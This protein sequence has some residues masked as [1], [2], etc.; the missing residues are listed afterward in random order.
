MSSAP[1][2]TIPRNLLFRFRFS[3]HRAEGPPAPRRLGE[4]YRL[5]VPGRFEGQRSHTDWRVGWSTAGLAV[6]VTVAD[7]TTNVWCK[8]GQVLESDGV[9]V[10]VDTRDTHDVHRATRYCHWLVALPAGA[11]DAAARAATGSAVASLGGPFCTQLKINR[12]KEDSPSINR[13]KAL[14]TSRLLR[15]GYE[16]D[17]FLPAALLNGWNPVEQPSIGFFLAVADRELGWQTLGCGPEMP[18][19]EDPSLWQTLRLVD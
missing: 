5:P 2:T 19:M 14:V 4:Q 1:L 17:L 13:T 10:W 8:P 3:C 16:L 12:A 15:T 7:R 18:I 6:S 11:A 9:H